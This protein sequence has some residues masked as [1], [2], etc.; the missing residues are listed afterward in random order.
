MQTGTHHTAETRRRI[1]DG[2]RGKRP[3]EAHRA[4]L[5]AAWMR[6]RSDHASADPLRNIARLLGEQGRIE[7]QVEQERARITRDDWKSDE[8]AE[9]DA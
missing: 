4:A 2:L 9:V 1:S 5:R 7:A 8:L 3:T 6:R